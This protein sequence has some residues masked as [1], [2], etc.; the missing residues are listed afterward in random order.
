MV[1]PSFVKA[2]QTMFK[3]FVKSSRAFIVY[4]DVGVGKTEVI[5]NVA[6]FKFY[7]SAYRSPFNL[8]FINTDMLSA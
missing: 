6:R 3:L 7:Q 4:G 5:K 1:T 2:C 8:H